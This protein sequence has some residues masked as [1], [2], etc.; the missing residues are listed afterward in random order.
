MLLIKS[1][2]SHGDEPL[3]TIS[4]KQNILVIRLLS[5]SSNTAFNATIFE[6]ISDINAIFFHITPLYFLAI[7]INVVGALSIF[8]LSQKLLL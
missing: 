8:R 6:C 1:N 3:S 5:I 4:P 7:I 2:V